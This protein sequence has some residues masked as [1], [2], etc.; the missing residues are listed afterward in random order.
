[1][2]E[3]YTVLHINYSNISREFEIL[4]GK[5]PTG[6]EIDDIAEEIASQWQAIIHQAIHKVID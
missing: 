6:K 2:L 4:Y 1:M 5:K 3:A